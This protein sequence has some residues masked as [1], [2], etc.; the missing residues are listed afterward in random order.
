MIKSLSIVV[1]ALAAGALLLSACGTET[2]ASDSTPDNKVSTSDIST[3]PTAP[4]ATDA[5]TVPSGAEE[6][7]Q[8]VACG[9]VTLDTGV[10]HQLI[11]DPAENGVVGCTEAFNVIDEFTKLPPEQRSAASLG[12]VDLPSGWSC[13]VDDGKTANVGCVKDGFSLHTEQQA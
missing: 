8:P 5:S 1:P 3:A 6:Q 9:A 2:T 11:A 4:S 7:P 10:V 12:N 13:T